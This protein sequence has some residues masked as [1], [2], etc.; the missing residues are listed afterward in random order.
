MIDHKM[1]YIALILPTFILSIVLLFSFPHMHPLAA[2]S[3]LLLGWLIYYVWR[4][5]EKRLHG[6]KSPI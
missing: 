4:Y 1:K 3:P 5:M 6:E 2:M